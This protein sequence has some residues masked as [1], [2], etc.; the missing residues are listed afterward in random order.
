MQGTGYF[1]QRVITRQQ[2]IRHTTESSVRKTG[3]GAED[4]YE[5]L[6]TRS[7][8]HSKVTEG[9]LTKIIKVYAHSWHRPDNDRTYSRVP[10]GGGKQREKD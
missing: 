9:G 6:L 1:R 7:A 2:E 8:N 10:V 4:H 3:F 5:T